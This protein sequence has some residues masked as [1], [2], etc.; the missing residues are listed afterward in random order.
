MVGVT[1]LTPTRCTRPQGRVTGFSV[2]EMHTYKEAPRRGSRGRGREA[3][4]TQRHPV[5]GGLEHG[6][7]RDAL[8]AFS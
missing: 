4:L 2:A 3:H 6:L 8:L 7:S 1:A 5:P